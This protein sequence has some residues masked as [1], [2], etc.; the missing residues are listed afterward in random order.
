MFRET[1]LTKITL[2]ALGLLLIAFFCM[3]ARSQENMASEVG[4][5]SAICAGGYIALADASPINTRKYLYKEAAWWTGFLSA[6]VNDHEKEEETIDVVVS[7]L[8][9]E[10]DDNAGILNLWELVEHCL[11]VKAEIAAAQKSN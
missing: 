3:P 11:A 2:I 10:S 9:V 4:E 8:K 7:H 1:K 6:W 5:I